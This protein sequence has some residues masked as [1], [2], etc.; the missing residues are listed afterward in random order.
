MDEAAL[1]RAS[2]NSNAKSLD[3]YFGCYPETFKETKDKRPRSFIWLDSGHLK[4]K[5]RDGFLL[6]SPILRCLPVIFLAL[7]SPQDQGIPYA[8]DVGIVLPAVLSRGRESIL[9]LKKLKAL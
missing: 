2:S 9:V 7:D 6:S 5:G 1:L 4:Q 8:F 3:D